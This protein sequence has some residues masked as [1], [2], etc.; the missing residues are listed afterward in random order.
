M[1]GSDPGRS[2]AWRA[3]K[4]QDVGG[5]RLQYTEAIS[6]A[7]EDAGAIQPREAG[8]PALEVVGGL[9]EGRRVTLEGDEVQARQTGRQQV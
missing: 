4:S 9:A 3:G 8:Q 5:G 2:I 1:A 6:L 7:A